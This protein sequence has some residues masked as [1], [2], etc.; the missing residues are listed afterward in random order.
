ML[1]SYVISNCSDTSEFSHIT[2]AT[3]PPHIMQWLLRKLEGKEVEK[4]P[5]ISNITDRLT[6][7]IKV[8]MYISTQVRN[9]TIYVCTYNV[10]TRVYVHVFV[11]CNSITNHTRYCI[12][13]LC[14]GGKY[15]QI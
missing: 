15:W 14:D 8:C 12:V 5:I 7:V 6:T 9:R 3:T 10:Y 13:Q 4:F 11:Y 2:I 1:L